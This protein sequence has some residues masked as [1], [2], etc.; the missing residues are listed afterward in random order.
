MTNPDA[1][2]GCDV[3]DDD[4]Q[5]CGD[6]AVAGRVVGVNSRERTASVE[7]NDGIAT[8]AL[9]L[10]DAGVGDWVLVHLGFAIE[11]LESA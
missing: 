2:N 6:V 11:L 1:A 10:V 7:M 8:V 3:R 4:C 9:D 5:L